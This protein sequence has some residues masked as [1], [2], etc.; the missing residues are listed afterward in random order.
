MGRLLSLLQAAGA[1][2]PDAALD[3][4]ECLGKLAESNLQ[5]MLPPTQAPLS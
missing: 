1:S 3:T 5:K 2:K 4:G